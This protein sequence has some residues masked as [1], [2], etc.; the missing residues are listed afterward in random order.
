MKP[1][2][3]LSTII[4][5]ML[6]IGIGQCPAD[7][8]GMKEYKDPSLPCSFYYPADMTY[9]KDENKISF[10]NKGG[11]AYISFEP[12]AYEKDGGKYKNSRV[13]IGYLAD[14]AKSQLKATIE[15]AAHVSKIGGNEVYSFEFSWKMEEQPLRQSELALDAQDRMYSFGLLGTPATYQKYQQTFLTMV[16]SFK[17]G[18]KQHPADID[19]A[20]DTSTSGQQEKAITYREVSPA[21]V[22]GLADKLDL[23]H[24]QKIFDGIPGM[25]IDYGKFK[26][27]LMF[28]DCGPGNLCTNLELTTNFS[29]TGTPLERVNDWNANAAYVKAYKDKDGYLVIGYD[30]DLRG[31]VTLENVM[32]FLTTFKSGVITAAQHITKE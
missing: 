27:N 28:H 17:Y 22:A 32:T 15:Q 8:E 3:L 16:E 24:E 2:A 29:D 18:A 19:K 9:E 26:G 12:M 4:T 5:L 23:A 31:G 21:M 25:I 11:S 30:M 6:V 7:A 13:M 14:N 20:V 1:G 10:K